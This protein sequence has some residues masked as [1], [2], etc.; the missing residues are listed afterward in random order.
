MIEGACG[1]LCKALIFAIPIHD[2][3]LCKKQDVPLIMATISRHLKGITGHEPRL[4]VKSPTPEAQIPLTQQPETPDPSVVVHPDTTPYPPEKPI[5]PL[6]SRD[7][8]APTPSCNSP[9]LRESPG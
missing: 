9:P 4:V 5:S 3:I 1:E 6:S 2:A 8:I 7:Q